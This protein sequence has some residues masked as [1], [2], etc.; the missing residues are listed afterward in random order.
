[1]LWL[2]EYLKQGKFPLLH[3]E[4][5]GKH[6]AP[7]GIQIG[8]YVIGV[9]PLSQFIQRIQNRPLERVVIQFMD[10]LSMRV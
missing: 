1:M 5:S 3:Q 4:L 8:N 6:L 7:L 2:I 10:K 9:N